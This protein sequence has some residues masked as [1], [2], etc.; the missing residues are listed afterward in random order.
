MK[1]TIVLIFLIS[2]TLLAQT[3]IPRSNDITGE[4]I[5]YHIKHLSSEQYQ[6]RRTGE[7]FCDS[8]GAYIERE[9]QHYGLKAFNDSYRQHYEILYALELGNKNSLKISGVKTKLQVNKNYMPLSFSSSE[10]Y[11]G[12]MVF[13]GY[14]ISLPESNYDDYANIDVKDKIAVI[15]LG[16]PEY[17][18]NKEN[19]PEINKDTTVSRD[20]TRSAM[21]AGMSGFMRFDDPRYKASVA[22]DKGAKAILFFNPD[23]INEE[24]EL[25]VLRI[26][27]AS[28]S[29]LPIIQIRKSVAEELFKSIGKN[30]S[31]EIKKI[32]DKNPTQSFVSN[33]T[34]IELSTEI[35]EIKKNT[36]NIVGYIEGNDP[37]LKDEYIVIGAHYD[38]LGL[39]G[40]GSREP[41]VI[42]IHPGADD[43]ASGVA[44]VL[45]LAQYFNSNLDDIGRSMIFMAFSGEEEGLLGSAHYVK[46]PLVPLE[47]TA[48]MI[49]MDMIG[50][51]K[52]NKL[53]ING[54]GSSSKFTP[55]INKHNEDSTFILT[56]N[57]GGFSSSDNS[58]F[59]GKD[60]PVMM[61]FTDLHLDYHKPDDTWDKINVEG[62]NKILNY[63]KNITIEL[64]NES[65]KIDFIKP[66]NTPTSN[67]N[68]PG[69][70][71]STGIIPD[72]SEQAEGLKIQGAREGS[73]AGKAGLISG[74]IIIKFGERTI[75]NLY[76]YSYALGEHRPGEKVQIVWLRDGQEMTGILELVRR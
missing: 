57:E 22:R 10:Q 18:A 2:Y 43:N 17:T 24:K 69:F 76:D 54:T 30:L 64:S 53:V 19:S 67:Q 51:M 45:E 9:F 32:D 29:G 38:H 15:M 1:K 61:F 11:K 44:G 33:K 20:S 25:P 34:K 37:S 72:F 23:V 39:G 26:G 71:V 60:I 70:R 6:G 55:L 73:P 27:R 56:L 48:L 35:K 31:D 13:V 46:S 42:K 3:N 41:D 16:I 14:G 36:F 66:Q 63:I 4:E 49:N 62:Q 75:K 59:Y 74:D 58:S 8:A 50:R 40:A 65:E 21:R 47:K 68:M 5:I 52:D 12:E 28:S 7:A